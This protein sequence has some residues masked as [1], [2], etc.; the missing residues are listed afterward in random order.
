MS[1]ALTFFGIFVIFSNG[2]FSFPELWLSELG[3]GNCQLLGGSV[4]VI[5][6]V[7]LISIGHFQPLC[8]SDFSLCVRHSNKA[9]QTGHTIFILCSHSHQNLLH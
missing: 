5:F 1:G 4:P 9:R 6:A 3:S 2:T 8:V 7:H